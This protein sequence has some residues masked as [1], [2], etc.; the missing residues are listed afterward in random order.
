[1]VA[2]MIAGWALAVAPDAAGPA[3]GRVA[4]VRATGVGRPPARMAGP[5]GRLMARRAAEVVAVRNLATKLGHGRRATLRGFRYV[6]TRY[7]PDGSVEVTV[8]SA[9]RVRRAPR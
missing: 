3:A 2:L 9:R 7:R 5:R 8:E 4:I 6:S 1:M